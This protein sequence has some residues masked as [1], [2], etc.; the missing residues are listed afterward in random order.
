MEE[1]RITYILDGIK[2]RYL[3]RKS[4]FKKEHPKARILTMHK[5]KNHE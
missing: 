4:T 3:G 1:G 5:Y 2:A